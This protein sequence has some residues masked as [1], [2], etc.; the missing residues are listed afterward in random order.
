MPHLRPSFLLD[1]VFDWISRDVTSGR[2]EN[3]GVPVLV[4]TEDHIQALRHQLYTN[5]LPKANLCQ[6]YQ[7][8]VE[9]YVHTFSERVSISLNNNLLNVRSA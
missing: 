4:E 5:Y 7:C 2:L 1:V 6:F 8:D 3:V 9:K